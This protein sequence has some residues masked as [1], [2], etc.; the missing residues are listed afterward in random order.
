MFASAGMIYGV[1][2]WS[3]RLIWPWF[4]CMITCILTSLAYC[5]MW[6]CGDVRDYWLAIT[7]IEIIG[8]FINIYCVVVVLMYYRRLNATTDEYEGKDRM[9][10]YKINR[11]GGHSS[12]RDLLESYDGLHRSPEVPKGGYPYKPLAQPSYIPPPSRPYPAPYS[13]AGVPQAPLP[14]PPAYGNTPYPASPA[15]ATMQKYDK[16]PKGSR[17]ATYHSSDPV[18]SWVEDQ[19]VRRDHIDANSE[20]ISPS[21]QV[22]ATTYPVQHSRSVPSL[23]DGTLV[24]HKDCRHNKHRSSSRHK[25]R[26]RSRNRYDDSLYYS[27]ESDS[28]IDMTTIGILRSDGVIDDE[29]LEGDIEMMRRGKVNEEGETE[30]AGM[31]KGLAEL[32]ARGLA[33]IVVL[34]IFHKKVAHFR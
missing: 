23:Y 19:Q 32:E 5:I 33:R 3:R 15:D 21:R 26:S 22:H 8:V 9:V 2:I 1:H 12:R 30:I 29:V 20:P 14:L 31:M 18:A 25:H 27:S 34:L 10:R 6:W 28:D 16:E 13:P 11:M 17:P 7:I 4:P 24:S